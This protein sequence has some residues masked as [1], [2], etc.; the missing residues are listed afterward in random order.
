MH[1]IAG[2]IFM[3][4]TKRQGKRGLCEAPHAVRSVAQERVSRASAPV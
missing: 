2:P 4:R 3:R 1:T